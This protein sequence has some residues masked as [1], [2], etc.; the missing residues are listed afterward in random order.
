MQEKVNLSLF[1]L[2]AID[3]LL[4]FLTF[5][6]FTYTA[7]SL[8]M[9]IQDFCDALKDNEVELLF[10]DIIDSKIGAKL[11]QLKTDIASEFS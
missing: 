5:I 9:K 7:L 6:Y 2:Y 4:L 8:K 10:A 11:T 1:R 3:L